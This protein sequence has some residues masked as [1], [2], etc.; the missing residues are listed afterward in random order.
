MKDDVV[1]VTGGGGGIGYSCA[2]LL[3]DRGCRV[4][5]ADIAEPKG[6]PEGA[7]FVACDVSKPGDVENAVSL[8]LSRFGR[9][10]GLFANAGI[11]IYEPALEM[12]DETWSHHLSVNLNGI[13]HAARAAGRVMA[14]KQ[15]GA[16]VLTSSVRAVA[17]GPLCSAY[18]ATKGAIISL[19]T[20]LATEFG[21][22]GIR[23]NAILP[24]AIETPMLSDAAR[25]FTENDMQKLCASFLPMIPL[26]RVGSA[27]EVAHVVAFLLSDEAS[28]VHGAQIAV[29]GGML[30]KLA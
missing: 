18:S 13:F 10:D 15:R 28:Y 7:L 21:P 4:V 24:G 23:V 3:C 5:V 8:L 27:E 2:R 30:C 20:A 16:M 19:C 22:L 1:L 14:D 6:L 29:D 12:S 17:T 11:V 9:L 26:G 25:L